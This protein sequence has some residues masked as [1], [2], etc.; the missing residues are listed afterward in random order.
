MF[1]NNPNKWNFNSWGNQEQIEV[2]EYLPS[3]DAESFVS[4]FAIQKYKV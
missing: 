2:R 4:Y 3:L 1:G